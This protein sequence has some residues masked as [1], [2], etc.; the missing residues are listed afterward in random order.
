MAIPGAAADR[1]AVVTGAS[2]GIGR[3]IA[4]LL[5]GRGHGVTLVARRHERLRALA[6]EL[7]DAHGVRAETVTADLTDPAAREGIA[8]AVG[9]RGLV[10]HVLVN[11]AGLST[12]GA[13][14]TNDA[15]AELAMIRTDVEALAHLC[16]LF[17]PGMV[18]RRAGAILNVA[19][20]AAFQPMP[21]QAGYAASKAFVVSYSQAVR[22]ELA[23]TGV[24]VTTLCPGPVETE[25]AAAAG[26]DDDEAKAALPSFMWVS[27]EAVAA[28]GVD[29]LE[30]G[31]SVVVP[32]AVNQV[33]AIGARLAPRRVL[34]PLLARLH[35]GLDR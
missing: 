6:V 29:G 30:R 34:V 28:A 5:A 13:V 22:A 25:F 26:F 11:A 19:S 4:R 23:G 12:V 21:G 27:Q 2:S 31:R 16:S 17:L 33:A 35:P 24:S 18:D 15:A 32:G 8:A 14:H 20:T 10:A 1:T 7:G 9:D 3:E